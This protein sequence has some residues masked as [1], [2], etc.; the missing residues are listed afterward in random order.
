MKPRTA[1]FSF[2]QI[3]MLM[4]AC[5]PV[6]PVAAYLGPDRTKLVLYDNNRYVLAR[7]AYYFSRHAFGNYHVSGDTIAL[8]NFYSERNFDVRLTTN[9]N[10]KLRGGDKFIVLSLPLS[11]YTYDIDGLHFI[12]NDTTIIKWEGLFFSKMP[13]YKRLDSTLNISSLQFVDSSS[14]FKSEKLII[15]DTSANEFLV[16][17]NEMPLVTWY[18]WGSGSG[19]VTS[20]RP[21]SLLLTQPSCNPEYAFTVMMARQKKP[22]KYRKYYQHFLNNNEEQIF[23]AKPPF[24]D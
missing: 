17:I 9:H 18:Q 22:G 21:D 24:D 13:L 2:L 3:I 23:L 19:F 16:F 11:D 7:G 4:I 8:E 1:F 15:T 5:R 14:C 10:G 12:I 6:K 20:G